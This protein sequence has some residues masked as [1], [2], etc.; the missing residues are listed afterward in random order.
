[1]WEGVYF[2]FAA[3]SSAFCKPEVLYVSRRA[4]EKVAKTNLG[5]TCLAGTLMSG[6]GPLVAESAVSLEFTLLLGNLAGSLMNVEGGESK[7]STG[8]LSLEVV[9]L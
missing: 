8:S 6:V 9:A 5:G 1:M 2:F 4:L 3:S 7:L